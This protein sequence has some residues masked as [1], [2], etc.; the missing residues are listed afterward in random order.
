MKNT[1]KI[2]AA[3]VVGVLATVLVMWGVTGSL[4]GGQVRTVDTDKLLINDINIGVELLNKA[5]VEYTAETFD[6]Y[7]GS[8]D[9]FFGSYQNFTDEDFANFKGHVAGSFTKSFMWMGCN[10]AACAEKASIK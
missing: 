2:I 3:F 6:E 1:T 5:F 4:L 9:E 10:D 7:L 8:Y